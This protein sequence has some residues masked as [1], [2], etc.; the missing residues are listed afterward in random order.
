[1]ERSLIRKFVRSQVRAILKEAEVPGIGK[2]SAGMSG[3][4][5]S[6]FS[7]LAGSVTSKSGKRKLISQVIQSLAGALEV[8]PSEV[9]KS[10]LD[11]KR[12][13]KKAEPT[14]EE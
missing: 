5:T 6:I 14:E 12:G 10:Y 8:T 11:Y 9:L 7:R 3:K 2:A 1:M 13:A 4:L